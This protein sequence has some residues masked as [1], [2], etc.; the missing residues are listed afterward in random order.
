[1]K[2]SILKINVSPN[3]KTVYDSVSFL[4]NHIFPIPKEDF[5]LKKI[6][7]KVELTTILNLHNDDGIRDLEQVS[8]MAESIKSG[9]HIQSIG[10]PN[11]KIVLT[12]DND[13]ILFDGHHSMLAYMLIG[14]RY[15]HE[16]LHMLIYDENSGYIEDRDILVFYGDHSNKIENDNW[17]EYVINWQAA[18]EK[19]L[20]IRIQKNMGELFHSIRLKFL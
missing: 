3:V 12:K 14:K 9:E 19:Q 1:M 20:S 10:I 7:K 16:I 4:I 8:T 5:F 15:L 11:I 2:F 17:R 13:L 18:K 6:K